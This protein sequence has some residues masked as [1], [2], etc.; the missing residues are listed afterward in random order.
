V[1]IPAAEPG[2]ELLVASGG[3]HLHEL[4]LLRPHFRPVLTDQHWVT[5]DTE[6]ARVRLRGEQVTPCHYPT[7]RNLPNAARNLVLARRVLR[8]IRPRRVVSSGAAVA[9]PFLWM[10]RAMGIPAY[11]IESA[12]R[13]DGPSMAGKLLKPV[14]R[15][16][17]FTQYEH[18]SDDDWAYAGSVFDDFEARPI[19]PPAEARPLRIAISVGTHFPLD[20]LIRAVARV[21]DE[22]DEV[23]AQIGP[24]GSAP[25]HW[26]TQP[27]VGPDEL[28][29]RLAWADV[30]VCHAGVGLLL[31]SFTQGRAPLVVARRKELGEA[32]DD[33]QLQLVGALGRRGL[34]TAI[35]TGTLTRD[36]LLEQSALGIREAQ[37][38][39][40]TWMLP[41]RR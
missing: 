13:V 1:S 9:V 37:V 24:S 18:W 28:E 25:A 12:A 21:T 38:A 19:E 2:T 39:P 5:Y 27:I 20:R 11:Y 32:V 3:G 22:R 36:T 30:V 40:T 16:G 29:K 4:E 10:A 6:D 23:F 26:E 35:E 17:L 41:P 34:V 31:S 7:S 8:R 15:G 33:H 14:L